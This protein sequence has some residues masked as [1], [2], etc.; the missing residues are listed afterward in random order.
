MRLDFA[1]FGAQYSHPIGRPAYTEWTDRI[2]MLMAEYPKVYA[3]ISFNGTEADYYR[4][5]E[6]YL[7]K[8]SAALAKAIEDRLLFGSDFMVNLTKVRSYAD[9]YRIFSDSPLDE[10][11]KHRLAHVNP[12]RFLVG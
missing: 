6:A 5:L 7:A 12:E 9:Y 10:E 2:V 8:R 1:H 3:D 11:L 4:W